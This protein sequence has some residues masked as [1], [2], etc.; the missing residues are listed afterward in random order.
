MP[1]SGVFETVVNPQGITVTN[2]KQSISFSP[3]EADKAMSA[4]GTVLS[5]GSY[6]VYPPK[7]RCKPFEIVFRQAGEEVECVLRRQGQEKGG[8][9]FAVNMIT[10]VPAIFGAART[11]RHTS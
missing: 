3:G 11:L 1:G 2:R 7:I 9:P 6:K 10:C 5:L 4:V 8:C